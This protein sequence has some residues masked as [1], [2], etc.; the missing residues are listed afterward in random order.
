MYNIIVEDFNESNVL[1]LV[2]WYIA[3]AEVTTN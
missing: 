3:F 2:V 1:P